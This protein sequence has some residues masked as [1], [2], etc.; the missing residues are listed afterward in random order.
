MKMKYK[1]VPVLRNKLL[2]EQDGLCL[3]CCSEIDS[4][5]LDHNHKNGLIRGVLCRLC[6]TFLGKIENNMVRNRITDDKLKNICDNLFN[7]RNIIRDEV[8]P[9]FGKKIKRKSTKIKK[10]SK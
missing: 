1:D 8:H 10:S 9:T 2:E 6:N 7:Y 5:V 3:L 4:P